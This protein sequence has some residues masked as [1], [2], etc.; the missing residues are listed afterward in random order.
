MWLVRALE[1]FQACHAS[2]SNNGHNGPPPKHLEPPAISVVSILLGEVSGA[3]SYSLIQLLSAG[4]VL[5][6]P[7][8]R[9]MI[10]D[11]GA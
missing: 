8:G 3:C 9:S 10:T 11:V 2:S 7:G 4:T 1:I 5:A 6:R